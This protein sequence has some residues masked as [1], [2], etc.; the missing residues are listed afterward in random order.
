MANAIILIG[1]SHVKLPALFS[2]TPAA[3]KRFIEFFTA[4]I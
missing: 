3:S 2:P 4:N 1:Q